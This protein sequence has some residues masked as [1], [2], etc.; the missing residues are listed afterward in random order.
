MKR[1]SSIPMCLLLVLA[2]CAP[3]PNTTGSVTNVSKNPATGAA[4]GS[5][6]A[7]GSLG[8]DEAVANGG[9]KTGANMVNAN[10]VITA[11]GGQ[12]TTANGTTSSSNGAM[13]GL[14]SAKLGGHYV[15][16]DGSLTA[17]IPPGAL[18]KDAVVT[19]S[20]VSTAD[21]KVTPQFVPGIK[22]NVDLGGAM[23]TKD[24]AIV[25]STKVDPRFVTEMQ[26]RDPNFTPDK[27]NLKQVNG[28]WVMQ[29]AVN[30]PTSKPVTN[31][32]VANLNSHLIED[33][34]LPLPGATT[35]IAAKMQRILFDVGG[36][37]AASP[38]PSANP[39][40]ASSSDPSPAASSSGPSGIS[41]SQD[42]S[43]W[44]GTIQQPVPSSIGN[45]YQNEQA[46]Q[47]SCATYDGNGWYMNIY[48]DLTGKRPTCNG[49]GSDPGTPGGSPAPIQTVDVPTHTV[50]D[51]DDP[52][53]KGKDAQGADI[54][55]DFP[56]SPSNG[57]ADVSADAT[58]LAKS[59]TVA[60]VPLTAT[61]CTAVGP[62]KGQGVKATAAAGMANIELVC[63]LFSPHVT[64][65]VSADT[66]LPATVTVTFSLDGKS[67]TKDVTIPA[68]AKS[69]DLTFYEI[70]PDNNDHK[71]DIVSVSAGP[72]LGLQQP[73]PPEQSV[74]RN[75]E[76]AFDI[77]LA[78]IAAH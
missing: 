10:G 73:A 66:A 11:P 18:S 69:G 49:N 36:S 42:C 76:Y 8:S 12:A 64:F 71:F 55:F 44:T 75:G 24:N 21:L 65:H 43:T 52:S 58:G 77:K 33:G 48:H 72:D 41:S 13:A 25:V 68:G 62:A 61:A 27:Y 54:R 47:F 6:V 9:S 17:D 60:G 67:D 70:V 16:P 31:P 26:K 59:F 14:Y 3:A 34:V 45:W 57:P 23:L 28:D 2:G 46:G 35:T 39:S 4:Q 78:N 51:S 7:G 74:H 29:M 19:I 56:W 40:P 30:G 20:P 63:P 50:W 53:L 32:G 15:S 38:A 22:F 5:A 1:V 37:D